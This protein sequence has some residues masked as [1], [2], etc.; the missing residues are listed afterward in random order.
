MFL[1]PFSSSQ[2]LN[3]C[4]ILSELKRHEKA[5]V[6][7]RIALKLLL[8]ELFGDFDQLQQQQMQEQQQ[9]QQANGPEHEHEAIAIGQ[10]SQITNAA[11][12]DALRAKLP[13]DRVA[14]L[15]IAYHNLAVQQEFLRKYHD[16]LVSYEK[17]TKVVVTHLGPD[18]PLVTS[19]TESYQAAQQKMEAKLQ[20]QNAKQA[21][22][23]GGAASAQ[24]PSRLEQHNAKS[25]KNLHA[26]VQQMP[27]D[28]HLD[29]P[30]PGDQADPDGFTSD[31]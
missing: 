13:P 3:M 9:Q 6:H 22:S 27:A 5:I 23:S 16:S 17:A 1:P 28:G 14:V 19:L 29:G 18:H 20:R 24:K 30:Y 15:A 7:A 31:A 25:A 8:M 26:Q 11:T 10:S 2:H 21:A 4:T 12:M